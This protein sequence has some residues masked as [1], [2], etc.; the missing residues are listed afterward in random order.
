MTEVKKIEPTEA[1]QDFMLDKKEMDD[2]TIGD[3]N[4][5]LHCGFCGTQILQ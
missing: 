3:L 5:Y 1:H 4:G 2:P